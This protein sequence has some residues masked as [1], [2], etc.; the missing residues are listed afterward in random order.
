MEGWRCRWLL[1]HLAVE[2]EGHSVERVPGIP[3]VEVGEGRSVPLRQDVGGALDVDYTLQVELED[4]M[5]SLV[6][7][8]PSSLS[9]CR[10]CGHRGF[11]LES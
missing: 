7:G 1:H 8:Q 6:V 11:M 4:G 2:G 3:F 5:V 9:D 10:T